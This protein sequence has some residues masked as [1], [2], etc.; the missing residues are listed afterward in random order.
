MCIRDSLD[1]RRVASIRHGASPGTSG[2][3]PAGRFLCDC[4]RSLRSFCCPHSI[5]LSLLFAFSSVHLHSPY[6]RIVSRGVVLPDLF[7]TAWNA[8]ISGYALYRLSQ[9]SGACCFAVSAYGR[10]PSGCDVSPGQA[11]PPKESVRPLSGFGVRGM[12]DPNRWTVRRTP[13]RDDEG[14]GFSAAFVGFVC[15]RF[16]RTVNCWN[17]P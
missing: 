17:P 8:T 9:C 5:P 4:S 6:S 3:A 1:R 12:P 14:R 11:F 16:Y 7:I 13:F 10:A 2:F 15:V